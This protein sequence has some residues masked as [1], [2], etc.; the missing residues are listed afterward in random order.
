M[1]ANVDSIIVV[2]IQVI[3][4]PSDALPALT[5][6]VSAECAENVGCYFSYSANPEHTPQLVRVD[7]SEAK[8]LSLCL[9][10]HCSSCK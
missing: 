8:I 3:V 7:V 10:W 2:L 6:P 5:K 9:C 4:L 1:H